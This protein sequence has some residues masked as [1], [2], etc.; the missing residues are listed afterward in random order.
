MAVSK[1]T[2]FYPCSVERVWHTMTDLTNTAW[3][4]DLTGVE[5]LDDAHFV[6][7]DTGADL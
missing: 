7:H 2:A 3:R 4:S 5:I 1:A 6:E